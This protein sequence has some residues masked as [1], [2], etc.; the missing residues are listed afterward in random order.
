MN[1]ILGFFNRSQW[2][3]ED[4]KPYYDKENDFRR[5]AILH[6]IAAFIISPIFCYFIYNT[7]VSEVY[8][9]V[10]IS[11]TVL[12]PLYMLICYLVKSLNNKLI[13]FFIVHLFVITG[14]TFLDLVLHQFELFHFFSFFGLYS[15]VLYVMQRLYPAILYNFY[16][17][18]MLIYGYQF[19]DNPEI[20]K[21]ASFGLFLILAISSILVLWSRQRMIN[22][23][24]DY[25]NYLKKI[26]NTP[27]AGY[28]LFRFVNNMPVVVD[29]NQEALRFF[30]SD[31][32]G[33]SKLLFEP[34]GN[35]EMD[36]IRRLKLGNDFNK[37]YLLQ[38]RNDRLALEY[39]ISVLSLKNGF[40]WLVSLKDFT[41]ELKE[42]EIIEAR[43]LKYK[44]LYYRNQAGVFTTDL[45]SLILD[46]NATFKDMF[47]GDIRLGDKLFEGEPNNEWEV[48][49][50]LI[51]N[52]ENLRNYQTHFK[53]KNGKTKWFIFNWYFDKSTS[54]IE[55][56]IIDLTEV[57]K[58]AFAL[59]QSEEK[60]RQIYEESNDV[61]LLLQGDK[62]ID[63]NRKGIQLFGMSKQEL[64]TKT[65]WDLSFD[66]TEENRINYG[67]NMKRLIYSKQTKFYWD[68][69]S[70]N[71]RIEVEVAIVELILGDQSYYQCVIHDHTELNETMRVL[72]KNR[73]SFK[74]ILDNT[75][76][77]III[78][79]GKNV[80][81]SNQEAHR[82]LSRK[83]IEIDKIFKTDEQRRFDAFYQLH[84]ES[85]S[86]YQQ[87]FLLNKGDNLEAPID[88]TMV[89][90]TFEELE[91]TMIIFK[92]VSLQNQLSREMLRAEIAEESNKKLA[93]EIKER[94]K[95]E[96]QL[97]EQFLRSNAI[98][99]SSSNT[100]L[101]TLN[102][103]LTISSF[104]T[105]CKVYFHRI[106]NET[107]QVNASFTEF[108]SKIIKRPER[109]FFIMQLKKVLHGNSYQLEVSFQPGNQLLWMEIF[110]NPIYDS[111][112]NVCEISLVAHDIT[113]KKY[114]EKKIIES[115]KEKEVLLKEIHHRVKNNL[116]VISSI[117][118]LQ[119]S[120]V[121][122]E[123]TLDI[124]EESRNRI[125]S[126][127]I[128]HE[129]L[130]QTSN[131][132]SINFSNYLLSLTTSLITSYRIH[133]GVVELKTQLDSVELALDQAIPCGL[134]VNELITNALKYAFPGNRSGIIFLG[135]TE[136]ETSIELVISDDGIG[137]PKEF[138]ILNSDTLGLQLVNTLVEQLDGEIKVEN[139]G[140]IKYLITFDKA[141]I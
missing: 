9:Y 36:Q 11:Y 84:D 81:Y 39:S 15:V 10:G 27:G 89:S 90:T 65:L 130:Y 141:Q 32:Q 100:L 70:E 121:N 101:L 131:F 35:Q 53:L 29:F 17:L 61:I 139:S 72:E 126:M 55:G 43:E 129:N 1:Q 58:A 69:K 25:S 140:G 77:G 114:T 113:E 62:I 30:E 97:Q 95:A 63:T 47:E 103:S 67:S 2:V 20:A 71:Q 102:T 24:E 5:L 122:D 75:P 14:I 94:I 7:S 83:D 138:S 64:A 54:L 33:L 78:V 111:E 132:S 128:I 31:E 19:V 18:S 104:N 120:F 137:M 3:G 117:L 134:L 38:S 86:I 135:L 107:M 109:L 99:E 87:Q 85:K 12:F 123:K 92:D 13:Y 49:K 119:S 96:K 118:N 105:H 50:D 98:F 110:L 45:S 56:T 28:V 108:L 133:S 51:Q 91:A 112:G 60:Y 37:I 46:C 42:K 93:K 125:R 22:N 21:G 73:I 88:V 74:T 52:N 124:L 4:F 6:S 48:I 79:N 16:V 68:F 116:Q 66:R 23:V 44:N 127:A 76:E 40:Y 106:L 57:Q 115:L 8:F 136:K 80:L 59:R 41:R 26:V 34:V 82:L